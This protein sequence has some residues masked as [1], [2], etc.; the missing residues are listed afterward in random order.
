MSL[1]GKCGLH[2]DIICPTA[3]PF[4]LFPLKKGK[5]NFPPLVLFPYHFSPISS[6]LKLR[7]FIGSHYPIAA[8]KPEKSMVRRLKRETK[9]DPEISGDCLSQGLIFI[10]FRLVPGNP[11][12]PQGGKVEL[13][14]DIFCVG[15]KMISLKNTKKGNL[16]FPLHIMIHYICCSIIIISY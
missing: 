12:L 5:L 14:G 11:I 10:Y 13:P 4:S 3:N 2:W 16:F 6:T 1:T 9:K 15:T 7:Q 8:S